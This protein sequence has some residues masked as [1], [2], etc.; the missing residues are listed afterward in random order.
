MNKLTFHRKPM[1]IMAEHRPLYKVTQILLVLYLASRGKKSSLIRLHLFSWALKEESRKNSL[2]KSANKEKILFDVWGVDPAVNIAI[3]FA[4][5]QELIDRAGATYKL[6][7]RGRKYIRDINKK[8]LF[9]DDYKF[10]HSIGAR[11]TEQMVK[12]IVREWE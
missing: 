6:S 4:V 1:P 3:Q 12:E 10:L 5:A 11:I 8:D 2:Q 7:N 9:Y